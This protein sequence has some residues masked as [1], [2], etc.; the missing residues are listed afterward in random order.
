MNLPLLLIQMIIV[1]ITIY[2]GSVIL[3]TFFVNKD[4]MFIDPKPK[5][6]PSVTIAIPAYNE[7]KSIRRCIEHVLKLDYPKKI[8]VIVINDGSTD[9]TEKII[10][11]FGNKIKFINRKENSGIKSIPLNMALK[12]SKGEIFGFV[13]AET[14]IESHSLK[15]L[16]GYFND[17]K[18]GSVLPAMKVYNPKNL[19]ERIQ[20]IE[21]FM[22]VIFARKIMTFLNSLYMVP[23]CGF[24]RSDILKRTGGFDENNLSEDLEI[25]LRIHNAGYKIENSI[26]ALAYTVVPNNL[27]SLT[28]QRIR[29]FRGLIKNLRKYKFLIF[30]KTDFGLFMVPV[31]II[32]G[33]ISIVLYFLLLLMFLFD[34]SRIMMNF[35]NGFFMSGFDLSLL[36]P[37]MVIYPNI[38]MF[39][40]VLFTF[41]FAINVFL[42]GKLSKENIFASM[43]DILLFMF[44]YTP[45]VGVWWMLSIIQE[46]IGAERTW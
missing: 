16:I 29:W 22:S 4:K 42:S 44:I 15:K 17:P 21:Y 11:S 26:N 13:D 46:I 19:L 12:K 10:K 8:E 31:A 3:I 39:L 6:Y 36:I 32:G 24:F 5:R 9:K 2:C 18:V 1:S 43:F 27:R 35:L 7:E 33:T 25:G 28:K 30:E 23:G 14:F 38:I 34:T 45:L 37:D 20:R 40:F 41:I